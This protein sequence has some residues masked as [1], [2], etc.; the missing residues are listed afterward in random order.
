MEFL[1]QGVA[2]LRLGI[3]IKANVFFSYP[4][5]PVEHRTTVRSCTVILEEALTL[6]ADTAFLLVRAAIGTGRVLG[7][8]ATEEL[9]T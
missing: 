5:R 3:A 1:I 9:I 2:V 7:H 4:D 8:G 6:S